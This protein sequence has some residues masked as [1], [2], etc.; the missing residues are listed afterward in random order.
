MHYGR[1]QV[2]AFPVSRPFHP[3]DTK[4]QQA[5]RNVPWPIYFEANNLAML[6]NP[7]CHF[8]AVS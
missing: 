2:S 8:N 5:V 4:L 7:G 3:N 6:D 1:L